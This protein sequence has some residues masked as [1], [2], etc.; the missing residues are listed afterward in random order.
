M[1]K[2]K[3]RTKRDIIEGILYALMFFAGFVIAVYPTVSDVYGKARDGQLMAKYSDAIDNLSEDEIADQQERAQAYN[4]KLAATSTYIVKSDPFE[5]G[6]ATE[7]DEADAEEYE[8]LLKS[9]VGD[10]MG[11]LD[12]PSIAVSLP[13]YHYTNDTSLDK[14]VGHLYGSSLPVGGEST[15]SILVAHRG[16]PS[17]KLF[18][19]LPEVQLHD[20]FYINV[21]GETLAYE[22]DTIETVYP[23][24]V[25]GLKIEQGKDLVTLVTCTPYSVNTYRL[26]VTGHRVE[27]NGESTTGTIVDKIKYSLDPKTVLGLGIMAFIIFVSAVNKRDGKK[28]NKKKKTA[29]AKAVDKNMT[30]S[31]ESP[32]DKSPGE[33][34]EEIKHHE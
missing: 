27:Y 33:S 28:K 8:S 9:S 14:G 21:L 11:T 7:E 6:T 15:H 26:L 20:K 32:G 3:R 34:G 25:D 12:I 13:I 2:K 24:D 17:S 5:N 16:L 31:D 22:V 29:G 18:S 19:D 10:V 23:D 1:S 30:L 4:E